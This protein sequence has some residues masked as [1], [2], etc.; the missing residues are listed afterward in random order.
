MDFLDNLTDEQR[1]WLA[2]D[3]VD[4]RL[5]RGKYDKSMKICTASVKLRCFETR[6]VIS[7]GDE[8]L[9]DPEMRRHYSK[10]STTYKKFSEQYHASF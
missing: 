3:W 10:K 8:Y 4:F 5:Q 7:V 1:D 6:D 9:F 2:K